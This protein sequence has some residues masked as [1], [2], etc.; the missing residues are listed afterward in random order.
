MKNYKLELTENQLHLLLRALDFYS[1]VSCGQ[2][3]EIT[4][5]ESIES[6]LEE[7]YQ[8]DWGAIGGKRELGESFLHDAKNNLTDLGPH[9]SWGIHNEKVAKEALPIYEM[10]KTIDHHLWLERDKTSE[11]EVFALGSVDSRP[12]FAIN[13]E[14]LNK[15][16]NV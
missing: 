12:Y 3:E 5:L 10:K 8:K 15:Q 4:R 14:T 6:Y 1:R 16:E 2:F 9:A 7:K 11:F 13:I